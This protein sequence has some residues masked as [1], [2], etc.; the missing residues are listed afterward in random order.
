METLTNNKEQTNPD[1]II[2]NIL[3][4]LLMEIECLFNNNNS[5]RNFNNSNN[6]CFNNNNKDCNY[7][8]NN[9][10]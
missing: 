9:N 3:L 7:S 4:L 6:K 2:T 8:N 5:I 10:N 1:P